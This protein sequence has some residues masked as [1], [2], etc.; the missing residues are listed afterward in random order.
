MGTFVGT[1]VL[2]VQIESTSGRGSWRGIRV[3][4]PV[5]ANFAYVNNLFG[6]HLKN[7]GTHTQISQVYNGE[8]GTVNV[9]LSAISLV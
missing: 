4:Q 7:D 2:D 6:I 5:D 8:F 1:L 9:T 3:T